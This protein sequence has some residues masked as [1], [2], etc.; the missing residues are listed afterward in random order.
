MLATTDAAIAEVAAA[1]GF[2]TTSRFYKAFQTT[3]GKTPRA[4]RESLR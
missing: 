4:Y 2:H 3:C 1:S